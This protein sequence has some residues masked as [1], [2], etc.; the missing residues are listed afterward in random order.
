MKKQVNIL[1]YFLISILLFGCSASDSS[2]NQNV[3]NI[4]MEQTTMDTDVGSADKD[5]SEMQLIGDKVIKT[6]DV[7]YKTVHYEDTISYLMNII[8]NYKAYVEYSYES[9]YSEGS[10]TPNSRIQE[11]RIV[12]YTF[13]VPT[14]DLAAFLKDMEG[15]EAV[16]VSEQIGSQ[17]VTQ[18]YRDTETRIN[19][20]KKKENRLN[21]L[22]DQAETIDQI[23]QIENSLSDTISERE[24]LQSQL[25]N[26]DD[27]IDY[28]AVHMSI[29]ER[30]RISASS[31][32]AIP[33]WDRVKEALLDSVFVF[34]YWVQN[35]FIWII[36][37]LPFLII[38][39]IIISVFLFI[40]KNQKNKKQK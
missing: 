15:A 38:I 35:A 39:G 25:D 29:E 3:E 40:K 30:Q 9:T 21:D 31:G 26:F 2:D 33:F 37:A 20:L 12:N 13:R 5:S 10:Y 18:M 19:V 4:G 34:Y 28:T 22:M 6:V 23:I 27:L 17:D 11:Y 8:S 16:K 32:D 7:N 24:Q 1:L 14:K 36:Y